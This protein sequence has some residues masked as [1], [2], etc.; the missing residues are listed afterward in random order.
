MATFIDNS[1]EV[2]AQMAANKRAALEAMGLAAVELTVDNMESGYGKP[3]R[4]T[5]DLM[6]DVHHQV[7]ANGKDTVSVGNSLSYAPFV[8]EGTY[9]MKARHYLTDALNGGKE[10]LQSAAETELKK[11]F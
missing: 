9:K 7:E 3:I 8:H 4:Q 1:A 10:G 6:R 11:G 2:L 5:G